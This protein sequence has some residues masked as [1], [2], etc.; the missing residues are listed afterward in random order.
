MSRP[1]WPNLSSH[2]CR[3]RPPTGRFI[4][5]S[6]RAKPLEGRRSENSSS[7]QTVKFM[8]LTV[9]VKKVLKIG[10][11]LLLCSSWHI[12]DEWRIWYENISILKFFHQYRKVA[13]SNTSRLE[14]HAGFFRL[15]MKGIFDPY[16]CTVTFW[17]KVYL[18]ISNAR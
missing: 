14:A 5:R 9:S 3:L 13:S 8:F 7:T 17:Q 2:L 10:T 1:H 15:F 12:S 18:L 4:I 11:L 6:V 16:I